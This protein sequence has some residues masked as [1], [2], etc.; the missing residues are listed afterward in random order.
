[1][2]IFRKIFWTARISKKM[3]LNVSQPSQGQLT[4]VRSSLQPVCAQMTIQ[5]LFQSQS[6][7]YAYDQWNAV[8][9][10]LSNINYLCLMTE[11]NTNSRLAQ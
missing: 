8:D 6:L 2:E 3:I 10:F 7:T 1:M 5:A 9:P 4:I 11:L